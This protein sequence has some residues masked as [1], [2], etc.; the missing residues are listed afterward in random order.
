M[1]YLKQFSTHF[2]TV[3]I[4]LK[5][6]IGLCIYNQAFG[7]VSASNADIWT[8]MLDH[9]TRKS[10][11]DYNIWSQL[12]KFASCQRTLNQRIYCFMKHFGASVLDPLSFC[13]ISVDSATKKKCSAL[14]LC[15][16]RNDRSPYARH[17]VALH[18]I[19]F[20]STQCLFTTK[21]QDRSS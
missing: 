2:S 11:F 15:F 1:L 9:Q 8:S 13:G 10:G 14:H 12:D 17:L 21:P 3:S 18:E 7:S 20:N 19:D 4:M 5:K 6:V 16:S